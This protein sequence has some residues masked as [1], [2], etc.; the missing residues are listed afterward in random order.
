[1]QGRYEENAQ[2]HY[3][4]VLRLKR[5]FAPALAGLGQVRAELG[6]FAEA[7]QYLRP[8]GYSPRQGA[9][10]AAVGHQVATHLTAHKVSDADMTAM[11]ALLAGGGLSANECGICTS[12][13]PRYT[14]LAGT[15]RKRPKTSCMPTPLPGPNGAERGQGYQPAAPQHLV[16]RLIE[17]FRQEFS[18][19]PFE[20]FGFDSRRPIFI[21]GLPRSGAT[22]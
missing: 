6:D 3:H 15:S 5:N 16:D 7:E 22:P 1:M 2:E 11:Q 8:A 10:P 13:S 19:P 4:L 18:A 14:T 20:A 21:F 12:V 9:W 17:H